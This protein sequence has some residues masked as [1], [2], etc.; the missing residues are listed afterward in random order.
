[1][2]TSWAGQAATATRPELIGEGGTEHEGAGNH[3]SAPVPIPAV[4]IEGSPQGNQQNAN[5]YQCCPD[6]A[7]LSNDQEPHVFVHDPS[8]GI[9]VEPAHKTEKTSP[10]RGVRA[11]MAQRDDRAP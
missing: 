5:S 11:A 8:D 10:G 4:D 9:D 2:D 1:M 3:K 6:D 7:F